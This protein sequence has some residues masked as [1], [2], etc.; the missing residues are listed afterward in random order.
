MGIYI[1]VLTLKLRLVS[2]YQESAPF[3]D[4]SVDGYW[5]MF[6]KVTIC[7]FG[8]NSFTFQLGFRM[9][10]HPKQHHKRTFNL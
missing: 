4:L 2:D 6:F 1:E 7:G 9:R 3:F 5:L 10:A 8:N